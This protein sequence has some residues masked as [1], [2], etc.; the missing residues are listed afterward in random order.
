MQ[1]ERS[2]DT[3]PAETEQLLY[4]PKEAAGMV[5]LTAHWLITRARKGEI[6][7]HRVGKLY[8][9]GREDLEAIKKMHAQPVGKKSDRRKRSA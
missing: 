8:R 4:T 6:P 1:P 3:P 2:S 9:F 5:S 7:H